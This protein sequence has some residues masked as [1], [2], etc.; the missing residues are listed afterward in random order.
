MEVCSL[1]GKKILSIQLVGMIIVLAG[2]TPRNGYLPRGEIHDH[3][4]DGLLPVHGV[5]FMV[6]MIAD[7]IRHIDMIPQDGLQRLHAVFV[8]FSQ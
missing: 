5:N 7:R 2:T 4:G 6:G 8:V 3:A 1:L